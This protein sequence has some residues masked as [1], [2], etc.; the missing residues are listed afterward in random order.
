MSDFLTGKTSIYPYGVDDFEFMHNYE[1]PELGFDGDVIKANYRNRL[2]DCVINLETDL[3]G[4][5]KSYVGD[6]L[7][8]CITTTV[9]KLKLDTQ[10]VMQ[11][12]QEVRSF[13][14]PDG[15]ALAMC[16][17]YQFGLRPTTKF[18]IW[19]DQI[20]A[21][22]SMQLSSRLQENSLIFTMHEPPLVGN[23]L[24]SHT[25]YA[26]DAEIVGGVTTGLHSYNVVWVYKPTGQ[27]YDIQETK[28]TSVLATG[29]RA[30]DIQAFF[31]VTDVTDPSDYAL[32]VYRTKAG[33]SI[34]YWVADVDLTSITGSG[35]VASR[36]WDVYTDTT[37]D[38][39][40]TKARPKSDV[41]TEM[42]ASV[43]ITA[44]EGK[45]LGGNA[46]TFIASLILFRQV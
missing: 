4:C 32:R 46:G 12:P 40:L 19:K 13:M 43:K 22:G 17:T 23:P 8:S 25:Q 39:S 33:G 29:G 6:M 18:D 20:D 42:Q 21:R 2:A 26:N 41:L 45:I 15:R 35:S 37:P 24:S 11:I 16:A 27:E 31:G 10:Y 36:W 44:T 38:A 28:N 7:V 9:S 14:C 30:V 3:L 1:K 34:F 5:T